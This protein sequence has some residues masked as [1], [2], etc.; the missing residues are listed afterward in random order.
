MKSPSLDS[1]YCQIKRAILLVQS[2]LEDKS[3]SFIITAC[4]LKP[5][6]LIFGQ[7][8]YNLK[9]YNWW[10]DEFGNSFKINKN[11]TINIIYYDL[12]L[13]NGKK[14]IC[15]D[16][17]YGLSLDKIIKISKLLHIIIGKDSNTYLLTFLG[18]DNYLRSY[19]IKDGRL[20]RVSPLFLG[21][22]I[23]KNIE[24]N[25]DIKYFHKLRSNKKKYVIPC[26]I[27]KEWISYLP[28][29]PEFIKLLNE[30]S[31]ILPTA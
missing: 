19:F 14:I 21:L 1:F 5:Y 26:G 27:R 9:L 20:F 6:E 12:S 16:L 15:T 7:Q 18:I 13:N 23:L 17:Y 8:K 22:K 10:F 24:K 3:L 4:R 28:C 30:H 2:Y 25:K 29:R 31:L 11:K